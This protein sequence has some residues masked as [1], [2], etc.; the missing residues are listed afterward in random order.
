M[1]VLA[2]RFARVSDGKDAHIRGTAEL[3][4][5]YRPKVRSHHAVLMEAFYAKTERQ[6]VRALHAHNRRRPNEPYP[7]TQV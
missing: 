6:S 4:M 3:E 1:N 2:V 5:V 7:K